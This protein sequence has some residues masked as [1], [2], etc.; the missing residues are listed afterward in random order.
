MEIISW[1]MSEIQIIQLFVDSN[2]ERSQKQTA[3]RVRNW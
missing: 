2:S 1:K 3:I